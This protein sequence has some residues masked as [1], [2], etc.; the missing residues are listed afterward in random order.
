MQDLAGG[1]GM[2]FEHCRI[3]KEWIGFLSRVFLY[4]C[5]SLRELCIWSS[6]VIFTALP[7]ASKDI[8]WVTQ[9]RRMF[10]LAGRLWELNLAFCNQ[11]LQWIQNGNFDLLK[12][13]S[14]RGN[15]ARERKTLMVLFYLFC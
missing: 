10:S 13:F 7:E 4:I 3:I 14:W 9:M 15:K 6:W 8:K 12:V 5:C 1:R 2:L 11:G